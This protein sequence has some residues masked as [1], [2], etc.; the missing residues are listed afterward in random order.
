MKNKIIDS[1]ILSEKREDILEN[2]NNKNLFF[3]LF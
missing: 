3:H 2:E 1:F